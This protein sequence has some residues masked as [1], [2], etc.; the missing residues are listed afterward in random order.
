ML[1]TGVFNNQVKE[2]AWAG[3]VLGRYLERDCVAAAVGRLGC[4]VVPAE[5][6]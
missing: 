4:C 1:S 5:E 2:K 6:L 3:E